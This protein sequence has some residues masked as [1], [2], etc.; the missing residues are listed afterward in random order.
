MMRLSL[1]CIKLWRS[2]GT[3]LKPHG[4]L[5]CYLP[6]T[7]PAAKGDSPTSLPSTASAVMAP[8]MWLPHM[9]HLSIESVL[10]RDGSPRFR[11]SS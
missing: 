6:V 5:I 8:L 2:I 3:K 11:M 10:T 4:R 7:I 1:H 9:M